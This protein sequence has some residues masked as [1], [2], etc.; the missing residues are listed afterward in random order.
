MLLHVVDAS[1]PLSWDQIDVVEDTLAE[2]DATRIPKILVLNKI[3]LGEN[4]G[5]TDFADL[6][7]REAVRTAAAKAQGLDELLLAIERGL[8]ENMVHISVRVP[9]ALGELLG[10]IHN[11]G[12]VEE[13]THTQDGVEIRALVPPR[14]AGR[15][16]NILAA[17]DE[18]GGETKP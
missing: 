12:V 6:G 3:D 17:A 18:K 15:L 16:R 14:L 7:Y 10:A 13:E 4:V 5:H 1:H 8:A 11:I 2:L 9:Y